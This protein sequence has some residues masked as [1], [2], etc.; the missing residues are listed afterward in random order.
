[1]KIGELT[2]RTGISV[3]MLRYYEG[4]GLLNPHRRE[5][6]YREYS[7]NDVLTVD[8]LSTLSVKLKN[9]FRATRCRLMT[10]DSQQR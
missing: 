4:Q 6:G 3:R 1:M 10:F 2:Q 8:R 9:R 5:S 7:E